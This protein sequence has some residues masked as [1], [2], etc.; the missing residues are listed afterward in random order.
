MRW[1]SLVAAV[2]LILC[3]WAAVALAWLVAS[4]MEFYSQ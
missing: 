3:V 4:G 1:R 2:A